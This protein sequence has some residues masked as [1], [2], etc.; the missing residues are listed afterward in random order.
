[1]MTDKRKMLGLSGAALLFAGVFVPI[2]S[3]PIMGSLNFIQNGKPEGTVVI[4]L[5]VI[6]FVLVLINQYKALYVTGAG[7]LGLLAL[8]LI[9]FEHRVSEAANG[10]Q[11]DLSSDNPFKSL[12]NLGYRS[13]ELQWGWVLLTIGA[14]L[15]VAAA[16]AKPSMVVLQTIPPE[17]PGR[18]PC[19]HKGE[20]GAFCR[21]C[22]QRLN[23]E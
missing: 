14:V 3:F 17:P 4:L 1:M 2:I 10:I 21:R 6:S 18:T 22:G 13:A 12:G 15:L 23:S 19:D 8:T 7:A 16:S 9:N 5:A 20:D 11:I